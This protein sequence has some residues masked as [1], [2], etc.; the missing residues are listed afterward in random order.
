MEN[1]HSSDGMAEDLIRSLVQLGCTEMH[2]KTI[3]E[4]KTSEIDN[5][6]IEVDKMD[7]L[8]LHM[9]QISSA[10][11]MLHE[12]AQLRREIML[13][14][15]QMYGG[16]GDKTK[17][18]SVKHL[19]ISMMCTFEAYQA[20]NNDLALLELAQR[21]NKLFIRALTEFLGVEITDCASCFADILK[22][23]GNHGN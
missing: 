16:K 11:E 9:D 3:I 6:L 14:L 22:G 1:K 4:K 7:A 17:W 23:G 21:Q 12:T 18:C 13:Y 10:T 5:G 19:G 2:C 20:S 8:S 15:F